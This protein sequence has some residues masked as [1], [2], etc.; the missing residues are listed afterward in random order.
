M[1]FFFVFYC[2][3]VDQADRK[4]SAMMKCIL[5][6]YLRNRITKVFLVVQAQKK[7]VDVEKNNIYRCFVFILV[8]LHNC[9]PFLLILKV[10]QILK[11]H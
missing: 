9:F 7:H 6:H 5:F 1:H 3:A 11:R 4:S 10:H 2:I 8:C